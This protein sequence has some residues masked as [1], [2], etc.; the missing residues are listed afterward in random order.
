MSVNKVIIVGRLGNDPEVRQFQNGGGVTHISVATSEKWTDKNTGEK[1]EQ[2]EWHRISLFNRLGEIAAQFLRKGSMVY[3]EG[4]LHTRKYTDQQGIE[5]YATE[6]RASEMRMLGG[7]N[8]DSGYHQGGN[9][10]GHH[11]TYGGYQN[12]NFGGQT[13]G[14]NNFNQANQGFGGQGGGFN[15]GQNFNQH[16]GQSGFGQGGQSQGFNQLPQ[17]GFVGQQTPNAQSVPQAPSNNNFG[18]PS[19]TASPMPASDVND[20]DIPF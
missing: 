18:S 10:G 6:I 19:P 7:S 9:F 17:N 13:Q 20:D 4:S 12:N 11:D 3:V 15:Q 16:H 8:N 14:F 1:K 5:R 2:T